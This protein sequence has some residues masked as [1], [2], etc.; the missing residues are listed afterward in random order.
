MKLRNKQNGEVGELVYI[1]SIDL[2]NF[3]QYYTLDELYCEWEAICV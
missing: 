3:K 2:S 1:V